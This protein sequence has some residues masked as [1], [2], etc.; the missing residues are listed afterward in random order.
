MKIHLAGTM[1]P[2][3]DLAGTMV[4]AYDWAGMMVPAYDWAGMMVPAYDLARGAEWDSQL[5][6]E[7][8][9]GCW[10]VGRRCDTCHYSG[11][12]TSRGNPSPAVGRLSR[13]DSLSAAFLYVALGSCW[14]DRFC[15]CWVLQVRKRGGHV[16]ETQ[17]TDSQEQTDDEN[18][19]VYAHDQ[20][21]HRA[22]VFC[23]FSRL[24]VNRRFR[25]WF[26]WHWL[27]NLCLDLAVPRASCKTRQ[28]IRVAA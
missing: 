13:N 15:V 28:S 23:L 9:Q 20:S 12:R 7:G 17:E 14:W 16:S 10:R 1:V 19:G 6:R 21:E 25:G 4:P 26:R 18:R 2:A 5:Q 3:Y 27:L 8:R 22:R 24:A 11:V